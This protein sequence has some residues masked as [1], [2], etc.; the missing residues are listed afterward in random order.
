MSTVEAD[1]CAY[2]QA[3]EFDSD[4]IAGWKNRLATNTVMAAPNMSVRDLAVLLS[5]FSGIKLPFM[6][7]SFHMVC[8]GEVVE[9]RDEGEVENATTLYGTLVCDLLKG[10]LRPVVRPL[11]V[12]P[13]TPREQEKLRCVAHPD[14]LPCQRVW[15]CYLTANVRAAD[16]GVR[17]VTILRALSIGDAEDNNGNVVM[18]FSMLK[19]V[20]LMIQQRIRADRPFINV[21][22]MKMETPPRIQIPATEDPVADANASTNV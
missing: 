7:K 5:S 15:D 12:R 21:N 14:R 4:T 13:A 3:M 10:P 16:V 17:G 11:P 2:A 19:I 20:H 1:A 6:M 18:Y 9:V 22:T 8:D